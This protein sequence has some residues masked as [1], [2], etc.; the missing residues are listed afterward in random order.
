MPSKFVLVNHQ[1]LL[2]RRFFQQVNLG[3]MQFESSNIEFD[4]GKIE[5]GNKEC[6]HKG[7]LRLILRDFIKPIFVQ[8]N[9]LVIKPTDYGP[10]ER[11]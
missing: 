2:I 8:F 10:P 11:K 1:Y 4:V 3:K 5:L 6:I 7:G 9:L